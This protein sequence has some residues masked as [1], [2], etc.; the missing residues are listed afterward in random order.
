M[1]AVR[2]FFAGV[3]AGVLGVVIMFAVCC[4]VL[5]V[6]QRT[7]TRNTENTDHALIHSFFGGTV[8]GGIANV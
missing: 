3:F 6:V 2:E 1:Y 5:F 4:F 8:T 7:R